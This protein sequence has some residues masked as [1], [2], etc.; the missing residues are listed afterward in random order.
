MLGWRYRR[1]DA[2]S[3]P[4]QLHLELT[5]EDSERL[6]LEHT[7]LLGRGPSFSG[8]GAMIRKSR[9]ASTP[10]PPGTRSV[11]SWVDGVSHTI[12]HVFA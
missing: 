11:S 5:V 4:Q 9:F 1:G 8:I 2:E 10:I 6:D 12:E 3:G 7:R